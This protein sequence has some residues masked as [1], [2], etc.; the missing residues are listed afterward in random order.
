V[1]AEDH[2]SVT[3][4]AFPLGGW[5]GSATPAFTPAEVA[6]MTH[7]VRE[8][9][10]VVVD[11]ATGRLGVAAGG[12]MV[13]PATPGAHEVA[14][15]LA[16]IYP[17]W[18]GDR[19]FAEAHRVRF[20]YVAGEMANGIATTRLVIEMAKSGYLGFFGAAGLGPDRVDAAIVQLIDA[21]GHD[22]PAW[23]SNLIHSPNEPALEEAVA[24][25]YITR[26]VRKV[27]ASAY[28]SLTPAVV[29]Y[30]YT[31]ARP[32]PAGSVHRPNMVFAKISRP[33]IARHFINPAPPA[34]LDSLV[35]NGKLTADE[36][37]LAANLA[38]AEDITVE[39]DSGGHT[40]NRPLAPLFAAIQAVRDEVVAARGYTRPVRLGAAGGIGTPHAVAAAFALGASYVL[41]GSINQSCVEAGLAKD[42]KEMLGQAGLADVTMAPAADM[43]ELGVELQ[44]LKRGTMFAPRARKLYQLYRAYPSLDEIPPEAI[45]DLEKHVLGAS[46]DDC[47]A[48]TREF[49]MERDPG[50]VAEAEDDPRHKMALTFRSYLGLSSRWSINGH[51]DRR[52]DYQIWCGPAMGAFNAWTAGSFLAEPDK[53]T[54]TQVA[55][56]LMEGAAV[57]TRAQ[58]FRA[59]GVAVP[60][61][62]F[63][64]RPRP[65]RGPEPGHAG[66]PK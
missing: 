19:S 28:M 54:V 38:V 25:L 51:Q 16:P 5:S 26:G 59:C 2:V 8:T 35:A 15:V 42:A 65:L 47:W 58:Q 46:V 50:Q 22:G 34:M 66:M 12:T 37:G 55:N 14:A 11:P 40:D 52:V 63:N 7:R 61:D 17:E 57:L 44:V 39:S 48:A 24:D 32:G 45:E 6:R 33:E 23:G 49:W 53:R 62:A 27:S 43:F 3:A 36:A 4:Q 13:D 21:L 1:I 60:P 30:A 56:N 29:R 41:T 31:G 20:P 64:Y 10:F 18:L 9:A